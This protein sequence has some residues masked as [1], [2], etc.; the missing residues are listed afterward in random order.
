[1][2]LNPLKFVDIPTAKASDLQKA[3]QRVHRGGKDGP[4]LKVLIL[5]RGLRLFRRDPESDS[6]RIFGRM[7]EPVR[8]FPEI[9]FVRRRDVA[10]RLGIAVEEREP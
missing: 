8:R 7:V 4:R 2:D 3:V 9:L 6:R 10:E 1:M 5:E